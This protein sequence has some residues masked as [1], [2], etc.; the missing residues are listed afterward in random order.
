[1]LAVVKCSI[2]NNYL[3]NTRAF[4][5]L[6][7]RVHALQ[8]IFFRIILWLVAF[9]FVLLRMKMMVLCMVPFRCNNQQ[10]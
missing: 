6:R 7:M 8:Y 10:S 3:C 1:V 5:T 9:G 4:V 2:Q